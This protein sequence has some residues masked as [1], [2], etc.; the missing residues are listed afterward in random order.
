MKAHG[1][2]LPLQVKDSSVAAGILENV[3]GFGE[4]VF[5]GREKGLAGVEAPVEAAVK[6]RGLVQRWAGTSLL[7]REGSPPGSVLTTTLYSA[8]P[9][10][11]P[12]RAVARPQA[13]IQERGWRL[14]F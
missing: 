1:S 4:E 13:S 8:P 5:V 3:C 7:V 9:L 12:K 10:Y 11:I 2:S 6:G 14:S